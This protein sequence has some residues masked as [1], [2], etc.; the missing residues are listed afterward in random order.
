MITEFS[1]KYEFLRNDYPCEI[2]Y[3]QFFK[4]IN[5]NTNQI[6]PFSTAEHLY[7][8]LKFEPD[9]EDALKIW[10]EILEVSVTEARRIGRTAD[11]SNFNR[12]EAMEKALRSK[13]S[14]DHNK[15]LVEKLISTGDEP[16]FM[17]HNSDKYWGVLP[18]RCAPDF[19]LDE[20]V[21]ENHMGKLLTKIRNE[22]NK[23]NNFS[24][25]KKEQ[26][27]TKPESKRNILDINLNNPL[28]GFNGKNLNFIK[29]LPLDS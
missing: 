2:E 22:L 24:D 13:F 29:D 7:Q 4:N 14:I 12:L 16:I 8:A 23:I 21:G 25:M 20:P 18:F 1:G 28:I 26:P 11:I 15:E 10:G 9:G 19:E 27:V 6:F 17:V 5:S 3:I